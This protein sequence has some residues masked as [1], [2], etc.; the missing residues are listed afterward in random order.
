LSCK[1]IVV[2]YL[3]NILCTLF[4]L[5]FSRVTEWFV[6]YGCYP[7]KHKNK[8]HA[9]SKCGKLYVFWQWFDFV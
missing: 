5:M 8:G 4:I 6:G 2:Q 3:Y 9:K 1:S 7:Q